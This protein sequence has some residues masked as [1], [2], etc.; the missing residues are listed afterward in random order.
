MDR[1]SPIPWIL[2]ALLVVLAVALWL[3]LTK[4]EANPLQGVYGIL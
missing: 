4:P 3:W 1:G 2:G